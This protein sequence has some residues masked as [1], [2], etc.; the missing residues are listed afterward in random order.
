MG[1]F[2]RG[3]KL[4]R[5]GDG[6]RNCCCRPENPE[7]CW[8][9]SLC[10]YYFEWSGTRRFPA[11]T[12]ILEPCSPTYSYQEREQ[13]LPEYGLCNY[14]YPN[15]AREQTSIFFD[16]RFATGSPKPGD[17]C[18]IMQLSFSHRVTGLTAE[19]EY[20]DGIF[21]GRDFAVGMQTQ[22]SQTLSCFVAPQKEA[23]FGYQDQPVGS[24]S[25]YF[26]YNSHVFVKPFFAP[27][28]FVYNTQKSALVFVPAR[29]QNNSDYECDSL[30]SANRLH[31]DESV[32]FLISG[33]GVTFDGVLHEWEEVADPYGTHTDDQS[34]EWIVNGEY[35]FDENATLTIK[36]LPTCRPGNCDCAAALTGRKLVFEGKTFT[37]G[38]LEQFSSED[39]LTTWEEFLPGIF[40]RD[41]RR[42]CD[43]TSI[44]R[45]RK[46][47][48]ACGVFEGTDRW[49]SLL[50]SECYERDPENCSPVITGSKVMLFSGAFA[51]N[52]SGFPIGPPRSFLDPNNPPDLDSQTTPNGEPSEG[53]VP[54]NPIPSISFV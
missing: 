2:R 44:V 46:A 4:L 52:D 24:W 51:C 19:S 34:P 5:L 32:D 28:A 6:L 26:N 43:S 1:L 16:K 42:E 31:L 38:S 25:V 47:E 27:G 11:E 37:Y 14:G 13:S 49:Y 15:V 10:R 40:I 7:E 12:F 35:P 17:Y 29:C 18:G 9:P 23:V 54:D 22:Y 33:N 39:G 21:G 3:V 30:S 53:C 20:L 48:V 45:R 8:C 41:D 50:T 36:M